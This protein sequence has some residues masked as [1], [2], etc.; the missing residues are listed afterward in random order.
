MM[1]YL[2]TSCPSAKVVMA[3]VAV[4]LV[5]V[6]AAAE[7]PGTWA[8]KA[9]LPNGLYVS[10]SAEVNGIIYTLGGALR[11]E[12]VDTVLAYD[13]VTDVWSE[14]APMPT[15]R[16]G[17][18]AAVVD[19]RVYVFG[20][21]LHVEQDSV[22]SAVEMYDPAT[23]SWEGRSDMPTAF[24]GS[25]AVA[26]D[27]LIY[28]IGGGT[29]SVYG[30]YNAFGTVQVYDP[31]ADSW[32]TAADMPTARCTVGASVMNG[33]IFAAGGAEEYR[34]SRALEVYLPDT[35]E[36]IIGADM[37]R[38]RD[39]HTTA[40]IDGKLYA[41]GGLA[42]GGG[43]ELKII[44][45]IDV[46]HPQSNLWHTTGRM[47]EQRFGLGA[48][49]VD[50]TVFLVGGAE[51]LDLWGGTDHLDTYDP[52]LHTVWTEVA[53]HFSGA[54]GS[55]WRT[56]VCAANLNSE[57][58]NVD[59][60][61]HTETSTIRQSHTIPPSAQKAFH[62]VVG[63]LGINGKGLLQITSDQALK[64][65]GR[66]FNNGGDGTFGQFCHF[67]TRDDGFFKGDHDVFLIG[68]RQEEGLFR[69]N[70]IFANTGIRKAALYVTLY[71]CSGDGLGTFIV[72]LDP[73]QIEQ[74]LEVF[75]NEG[76]SPN[77]GWGF[78]RVMVADGAGIR[79]SASVIDSRTNDATTIVA[80]R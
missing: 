7:R 62:D 77:V 30:D 32:D 75:A 3:V 31:T 36:W 69:T 57:V 6:A 44:P 50:D 16:L 78:A 43:I 53:A 63:E 19:N 46:Y 80:Q 4:L 27:G 60:V 40:A 24:W 79:I 13:P 56:D 28:V 38:N 5:A 39:W 26:V 68:L 15:A 20:G 59:L 18:A 42:W 47:P 33:M 25:A 1:R 41:L 29:G 52:D 11:T 21:S 14:K 70:L 51:R 67:E 49:V 9:D 35:D 64:V 66:T 10:A 61:L 37:P 74:R 48:A 12:A 58:A 2:G 45:E 34:A 8:A 71:R 22:I 55:H 65:A 54:H 23:D 72:K 76:A 73:G 17:A